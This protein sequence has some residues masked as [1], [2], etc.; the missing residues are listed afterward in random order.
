MFYGYDEESKAYK[1]LDAESKNVIVPN[2][3]ITPIKHNITMLYLIGIIS[4][5]IYQ[6]CSGYFLTSLHVLNHLILMTRVYDLDLVYIHLKLN[7][8]PYHLM[9]IMT[10]LSQM[11]TKTVDLQR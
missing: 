8:W 9:K 4:G 5:I 11:Q 1:V 7:E 3:E 10:L 6:S 2:Q